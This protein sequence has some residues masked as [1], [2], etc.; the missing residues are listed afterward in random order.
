MKKRKMMAGAV[1]LAILGAGFEANGVV[2]AS[3]TSAGSTV[4]AKKSVKS[5]KNVK[6]KK[7]KKSVKSVKSPHK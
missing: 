6:S 7:S 1:A 4:G 5:V 2:N 3:G